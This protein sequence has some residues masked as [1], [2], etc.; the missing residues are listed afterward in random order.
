MATPPS[1]PLNRSLQE[2]SEAS[3][4]AS[5]EDG[6]NGA[7]YS[8]KAF[9]VATAVVVVGGAAGVWG[10]KMYLGVKDTQEFA[11]AMRLTLLTRWPLLTSRIHRSSDSPPLPPPISLPVT[12]PSTPDTDIRHLSSPAVPDADSW[13][14]PAAQ[15]R[16][17]AAYERGGIAQ[18]A[19]TA[20]GELEAEAEVERRKRGLVESAT[21]C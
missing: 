12:I 10:L 18:F 8:L 20:A 14:W 19:E 15:A 2:S 3:L 9:S 16:L 13:N 17:A 7:L 6:F 21:Q 11:S 5:Q 1:A 4:R